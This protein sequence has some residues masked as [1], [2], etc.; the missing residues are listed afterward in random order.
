MDAETPLVPKPA[1]NGGDV[2]HSEEEGLI[3]RW[4]RRPRLVKTGLN[5]DTEEGFAKLTQAL[6][7]ADT[8]LCDL[9]GQTIEVVDYLL[10]PCQGFDKVTG[11]LTLFLR[12]VL[13][14]A[15]GKTYSA[16][17]KA[18]ADTMAFVV[19]RYPQTPWTP[20]LR[21]VVR[22]VATIANADHKYVSLHLAPRDA[23]PPK[24]GK[25]TK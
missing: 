20:P 6:A 5:Q 24:T 18:V 14:G 17:G 13:F 25:N 3:L 4:E 8:A 11:E 9:H 21:F 12:T 7:K 1:G 16:A 23:T 10:H 19:S 22:K 2:V 15:D